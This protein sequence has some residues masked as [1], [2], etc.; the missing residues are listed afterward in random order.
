M[1]TFLIVPA[2]ALVLAASCQNHSAENSAMSIAPQMAKDEKAEDVSLQ[3]LADTTAAA[4][5]TVADAP[6][7]GEQ[8]PSPQQPQKQAA[9]ASAPPRVDWN[10]KIIKNA[11]L[12][13]EV[14]DFGVFNNQV[15]TIAVKY[16]G[17]I[18][19][20][21]LESTDY[22]KQSR[23]T[24]RVPVDMFDAAV[25]DLGS[26]AQKVLAKNI[27]SKDVTG[28]VVDT[29]S[30]L[31]SGKMARLRYLELLKQAKNMEEV[32]LVQ[33]EIDNIQAD[34]EAAAGRVN[35]LNHSA[36]YSTIELT[37]F[38]ILNPDLQ[39]DKE[40]EPSFGDRVFD[41]LGAG[42]KWVGDLVVVL[43][44]LWPLWIIVGATL[45]G[46]KRYVRRQRIKMPAGAEVP[47]V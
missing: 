30:R 47:K 14:K 26:N 19:E 20:E 7:G 43:L 16:G 40:R 41:A 39:R 31:E 8:Q 21:H 29:R 11:S 12:E 17:Y 18:A 23:I 42:F 27:T 25:V 46:V 15:N 6:P 35:Y 38:Q 24:I 36:A 34:I 32:F 3:H 10:K 2:L 1:K 5:A 9:P 13:L 4:N 45:Y 33:K 44:T 37:C 22:K 28:E